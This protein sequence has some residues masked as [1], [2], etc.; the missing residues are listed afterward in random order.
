MWVNIQRETGKR[1]W[2]NADCAVAAHGFH[3]LGYKVRPFHAD[4]LSEVEVSPTSPV[5][6][7]VPVVGQSLRM[8]NRW[9]PDRL[10]YPPALRRIMDRQPLR[11]TL[12]SVK[13]MF[14]TKLLYPIFLKPTRKYNVFSSRVVSSFEDILDI[15]FLPDETSVLVIPALDILSSYRLYMLEGKC[16]GLTLLSGDPCVQPNSD[17]LGR[18][19]RHAK[20]AVQIAYSVD[21][22]VAHFKDRP[23]K[24]QNPTCLIGAKDVFSMG[25]KGL[26]PE[27][28]ATMI[29]KRWIQLQTI[30]R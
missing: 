3:S 27:L 9:M 12:G 16:V 24:I 18:L 1:R 20:K 19:F 17:T 15:S 22:A 25:C 5:M 7:E 6:G 11:K 26:T 13:E 21:V 8:L 4:H 23:E 14:H 2:L 28:Y 29:E 10:S 30:S